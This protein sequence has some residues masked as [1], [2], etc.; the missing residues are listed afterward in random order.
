MFL[1][2]YFI[3]STGPY[4]KLRYYSVWA[5]LALEAIFIILYIV[6]A[7]LS[8]YDCSGLCNVCTGVDQ[9]YGY[10]VWVN[11]LVCFCWLE[12]DDVLFTVKR[13]SPSRIF[14]RGGRPISGGRGSSGSGNAASL[15]KTLEKAF[16]SA[17][18]KGLDATMMYVFPRSSRR[19]LC[20]VLC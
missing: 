4:I 13:D 17:T 12:N 2:I 9:G 20:P 5:T 6:A 11:D 15:G 8:T 1:I 19:G 7:A 10:Y 18:K 3:L 14:A 16:S